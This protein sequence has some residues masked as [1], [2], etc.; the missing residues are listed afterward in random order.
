MA[1]TL[2]VIGLAFA[3]IKVSTLAG[4]VLILT[5]KSRNTSADGLHKILLM[6]LAGCLLLPL[7]G[8]LL[9]V[10]TIPIVPEALAT[11]SQ[12][13]ITLAA[14]GASPTGRV[15]VVLIG[16]Y[17]MACAAL[18]FKLAFELWQ[19]RVILRGARLLSPG[20][21]P[22]SEG[23]VAEKKLK[24]KVKFMCSDDVSGPVTW[25]LFPPV[26]VLPNDYSKWPGESLHHVLLH[27][28]AHVERR[29]WPVRIFSHLIVAILWPLPGV[30]ALQNKLFWFAELACDDRVLCSGVSRADYATSLL[31]FADV[32][33]S[34]TVGNRF[35]DSSQV[36]LRI[37]A[38]LDG[39]RIHRFTP[40]PVVA[41]SLIGASL[42]LLG[43]MLQMSTAS[44]DTRQQVLLLP[45]PYL[46]PEIS[47]QA[48]SPAQPKGNP[49]ARLKTGLLYTETILPARPETDI[50]I[51][52]GQ[53]SS[54]R[55]DPVLKDEQVAWPEVVALVLP[56]RKI[57]S[58]TPAYPKKALQRHLEGEVT[59]EFDVDAGGVIVNER[60]VG[61]TPAR[62]FEEA[63]LQALRQSRYSPR[64]LNGQAVA[65]QGVQEVFRFK[66]NEDAKLNH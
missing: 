23:D 57:L 29:D 24:Q 6:T 66:L 34:R 30:R 21:L 9:P 39:T 33:S 11:S 22:I 55:V 28:L 50:Q 42:L 4:C 53:M 19:L 52:Q 3:A 36:F 15:M 46:A 16:L 49:L 61:A 7:L 43:S 35:I 41:F 25:G 20:L 13:N 32:T 12:M 14:H 51:E 60:V 45:A 65:T 8:Y 47:S 48:D 62:V 59:I 10:L 37:D 31:R 2:D 18:I 56:P 40:R 17:F 27:E 63:A 64:Y 1:L 54:D 5:S 44:T 58:I 26:I 38:V